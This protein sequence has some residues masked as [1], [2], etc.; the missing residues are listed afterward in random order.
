M[1]PFSENK[2]IEQ[3]AKCI[4]N[5]QNVYKLYSLQNIT[6]QENDDFVA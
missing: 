4:K 3:T 2:L 6:I 5:I 1:N